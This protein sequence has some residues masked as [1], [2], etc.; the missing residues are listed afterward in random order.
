[1]RMGPRYLS[2][3]QHKLFATRTSTAGGVFGNGKKQWMQKEF[4]LLD[5]PLLRFTVL[6]PAST[7]Q[8]IHNSKL[9]HPSFFNSLG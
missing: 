9:M 5:S 6:L 3:Y 7:V 1:M 4:L 2:F 8:C